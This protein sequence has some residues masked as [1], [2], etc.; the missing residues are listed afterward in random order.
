MHRFQMS[1]VMNRLI[2]SFEK[3]LLEVCSFKV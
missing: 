3:S 1:M 2:K